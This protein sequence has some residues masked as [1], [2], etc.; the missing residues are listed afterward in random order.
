MWLGASDDFA[1]VYGLSPSQARLFRCTA[2]HLH[3][4]CQGGGD[5]HPN[6]VAACWWCNSRRHRAKVAL[7]PTR[8]KARVEAL[9]RRGRWHG[10]FAFDA[11]LRLLS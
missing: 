1:R 9:V 11:G 8:Y 10:R 6:I 2:E 7:G 5:Q 4:R 3:A